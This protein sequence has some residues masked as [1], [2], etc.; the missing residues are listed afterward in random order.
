M[1]G[2]T[3]DYQFT[4][5]KL[6]EIIQAME[7]F[8][9]LGYGILLSSARRTPPTIIQELKKYQDEQTWFFLG[10][11]ENPYL[12]FLQQAD[13]FMVTSD[14]VSMVSEVLFTGKPIYLLDLDGFNKRINQFKINLIDQGLVRLWS[15]IVEEYSYQAPDSKL[16]V[17]KRIKSE[18][19]KRL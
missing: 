3:K 15:G 13:Q 12:C 4:R 5:T 14:S 16:V 2:N 8:K 18:L 19:K 17:A 6:D 10:E 7:Q 11:G 9:Q 1:G